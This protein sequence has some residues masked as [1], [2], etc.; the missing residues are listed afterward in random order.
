[1]KKDEVSYTIRLPSDLYR[2]MRVLAAMDGV[3]V[4]QFFL[5][6]FRQVAE[7]RRVHLPNAE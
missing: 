7:Q 1:M 3:S 4:N 5:F 2:K 6:L